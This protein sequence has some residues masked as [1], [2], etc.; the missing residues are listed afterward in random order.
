MNDVAPKLYPAM[1]GIRRGVSCPPSLDRPAGRF[2]VCIDQCGPHAQLATGRQLV[3]NEVHR[4]RLIRP[5]CHLP[6]LAQL[7]LNPPSGRFVA[8]LQTEF[9]IQAIDPLRVHGPTL[10]AQRHVDATV[11]IAHTGGSNLLDAVGQLSLPGST[12]AVVIGCPVDRQ[13][14]ASTSNAHLQAT[15]A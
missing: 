9:A 2:P 8:Q 7:C 5:R 4:P 11:A 14:T 3:V 13:C 1:S 15:R 6:P 12:R 10:T